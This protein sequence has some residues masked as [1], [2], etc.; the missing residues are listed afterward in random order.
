MP[1]PLVRADHG[2]AYDI[3]SMIFMDNWSKFGYLIMGSGIRHSSPDCSR[4]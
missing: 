4:R 1:T 2:F 3:S